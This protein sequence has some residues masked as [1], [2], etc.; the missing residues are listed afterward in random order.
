MKFNLT[1]GE[2]KR[3]GVLVLPYK[4]AP[5]WLIQSNTCV[6]QTRARTSVDG[7]APTAQTRGMLS[8]PRPAGR[9]RRRRASR[10]HHSFLSFP[11][12]YRIPAWHA[13]WP[14][15]DAAGNVARLSERIAWRGVRCHRLRPRGEARRLRLPRSILPSFHITALHRAVG[16][17]FDRLPMSWKVV[18]TYHNLV[19]NSNF[20]CSG[21]VEY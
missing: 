9:L 14:G 12:L 16:H 13:S 3:E 15:Q 7:L 20:A 11:H 21:S 1:N 19:F 2:Q 5:P 10:R 6:H 17:L 18:S 4:T 8:R